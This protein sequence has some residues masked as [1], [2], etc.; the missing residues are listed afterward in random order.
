MTIT[1]IVAATGNASNAPAKP[2]S[3]P[4]IPRERILNYRS[5]EFVRSWAQAMP[6]TVRDRS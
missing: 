2:A 6:A 5:V 3:D 4:P 1:L